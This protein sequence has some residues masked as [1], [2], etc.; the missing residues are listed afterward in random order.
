MSGC[1]TKPEL[2]EFV[3]GKLDRERLEFIARHVDDCQPCQDTV[4][5]L[6][7][8]S[9]TFV[10]GIKPDSAEDAYD[11]ED[12]LRHG[13]RRLLSSLKTPLGRT[14]PAVSANGLN[15]GDA[16]QIGPYRLNKRLGTGGMG[17]VYKGVHE[18]LKRTVAVK[19]LPEDR[20]SNSAAISRFER[21]M[22]AIGQL[23]HPHI[24]RATD[25]GEADGMHYLV[26]DFVDGL[27]LSRL[28][29]RLGPLPV[30]DACELARQAAVGL[31]YVH[32]NR[33]IHRDIKPSNLM[34]AWDRESGASGGGKPSVKILDLGLALLGDEHLR[35]KDELTTV[36]QLMGTLDYMSPEQGLDSHD[37]GSRTDIYSLG[38]TLFKLLTG[39][40][41]FD[42]PE[43]STPLR[44][45]TAL[46]TTP[47]PSI[48]TIR[49]DLPGE[50]IEIVDRMLA[51]EPENRFESASEVAAALSRLAEGANLSRLLKNGLKAK[52]TGA[53]TSASPH[54]RFPNL[55]RQKRLP[56]GIEPVAVSRRQGV[57]WA[58]WVAL[59]LV[60]TAAT[61]AAIMIR[62][63]TSYGELI[64]S[65]EFADVGV[66]VR[67]GDQEVHSLELTREGSKTTRI[68]SGSYEIELRNAGNDLRLDRDRITLVRGGQEVVNIVRK[69]KQPSEEV[70]VPSD[71]GSDAELTKAMELYRSLASGPKYDGKTFNAWMAELD[72]ERN[73]ERLT[74]AV[75]ALSTL[76]DE[77]KAKRVVGAL[78]AIM[79]RFGSKSYG[80]DAK[81]KLV[82]ATHEAFWNDLPA[83]MVA[84]AALQEI[85]VGTRKSRE[86]LNWIF[87]P[88]GQTQFYG[89]TSPLIQA[90]NKRVRA[91][92]EQLLE[93]A[94]GDSDD[95]RVW[96]F[97]QIDMLHRRSPEPIDQIPTLQ[98]QLLEQL[99]SGDNRMVITVAPT[100][101]RSAPDSPGLVDALS[102]VLSDEEIGMRIKAVLNL[103][104]LGSKAAPAVP[105]LVEL[106]QTEMD[107][108]DEML[109]ASKASGGMGGMGGGSF[110]G[111][112]GM[113][114]TVV[115]M[116]GGYVP[117][118]MM[119][120]M[121]GGY[122]MGGMGAGFHYGGAS[123]T[124]DLRL[125]ILNTLSAIGPEANRAIPVL[126]NQLQDHLKGRERNT[127]DLYWNL[128]IK[129]LGKIGLDE[130][131]AQLIE[132]LAE[133]HPALRDAAG[134]VI[135]SHS[136][137][138]PF[139]RVATEKKPPSA[140]YDGKSYQ[141]WRDELRQERNPE[142]LA[143]TV[144]ALAALATGNRTLDLAKSLMK[145]MRSHQ[146]SMAYSQGGRAKLVREIE[147]A[148]WQLPPAS[149]VSA[150]IDELDQSTPRS[151][152]FMSWLLAP[153]FPPD[154]SSF[155]EAYRLVA[156]EFREE[157]RRQAP[158][159][160][161][162]LLLLSESK[163]D[164]IRKWSLSYLADLCSNANLEPR[165]VPGLIE[166]FQK[167]LQGGAIPS[168][169]QARIVLE[170]AP[171]SPGLAEGL[172]RVLERPF[173]H[174]DDS[175]IEALGLLAQLGAKAAHAVPGLTKRLQDWMTAAESNQNDFG[176]FHANGKRR[177][178]PFGFYGSTRRL[179]SDNALVAFVTTLGKIGPPAKSALPVLHKIISKP[180]PVDL[181]DEG[182]VDRRPFGY[183][184]EVVVAAKAA[185]KRITGEAPEPT[186]RPYSPHA[187][188]EL[189]R[190]IEIAES[191]AK[192][193]AASYAHGVGTTYSDVIHVQA[194]LVEAKLRRAELVDDQ[195]ALASLANELI[196]LRKKDIELA[197][198]RYGAGTV[199]RDAVFAAQRALVEARIRVRPFLRSEAD[200]QGTE[201]PESEEEP[202]RD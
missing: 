140:N 13:L 76:N 69:K 104:L 75:K 202:G 27:D 70:Q 136:G 127:T 97:E 61:V 193:T 62:L 89:S 1:V 188:K 172:V 155:H 49:S 98:D 45:I 41:P 137:S 173:A 157:I 123:S 40:A 68:R 180:A 96:A 192:D 189:D 142:R 66:V 83:D 166:R 151:R 90:V 93:V 33:L 147:L 31:Q 29:N 126:M 15:A 186:S 164:T 122:M 28:V 145:L 35:N 87:T 117:S 4:I 82:E 124:G 148:T 81:G 39:R 47:A 143:E 51:R 200:E 170:V 22:E 32:D 21:E 65:S 44:K 50:L 114:G 77:T 199:S 134:T 46:A 107:R 100:L 73:P 184:P 34:L 17:T 99:R 191:E 156:P 176:L 53:E 196:Q 111:F 71:L 94:A 118:G 26:M 110:G 37:V 74:Q 165:S 177:D 125:D 58:K 162:K 190:L 152:A 119:G 63:E 43:F 194:A 129:T 23:N 19:I 55:D 10:N 12:A 158:R 153:V 79:R 163:S 25:A 144:R 24:V 105:Q 106:L 101:I 95:E 131:S 121:G 168:L 112:G 167:E 91:F 187:L 116:G 59:A 161:A 149:I 85:T 6:A 56:V 67:Q 11:A 103:S 132:Q 16:D 60:G 20:W 92:G 115:Q 9:D 88:Y 38:A 84:E 159:L 181:A 72:H 128:L 109:E 48:G 141:K 102:R 30:A 14:A 133:Q 154:D 178:T 86:F 195:D 179:P 139:V 150:M 80:S 185:V 169:A 197:E 8:Q 52:P 2:A 160:T 54:T 171:E 175:Q 130:E 18:K 3:L 5:A 57:R 182:V 183:L 138:N 113:G 135:A 198:R 201:E 108:W 64:I 36:G 42:E 120:G 7:E 146:T 174:Y 78:F